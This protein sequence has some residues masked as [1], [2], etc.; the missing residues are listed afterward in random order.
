VS[1]ATIGLALSSTG[2]SSARPVHSSKNRQRM[3]EAGILEQVYPQWAVARR[4][5]SRCQREPQSW[6]SAGR[7]DI[8]MW[9]SS[10]VAAV[11]AGGWHYRWTGFFPHV[12][13]P[14]SSTA[15]KE[16]C[17]PFVWTKTA[18]QILSHSRIQ[19]TSLRPH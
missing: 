1:L 3:I 12:R 5:I 4:T 18:N 6:R 19:K 13:S 17:Q 2:M 16:S 14:H 15:A 7:H 10:D 8:D 11:P 9:A